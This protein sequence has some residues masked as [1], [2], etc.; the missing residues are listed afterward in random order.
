[1]AIVNQ[2]EKLV[3]CT[4]SLINEWAESKDAITNGPWLVYIGV[5]NICNIDCAVCARQ[6][7]MRFEKGLMSFDV[8]KKIV[9]QLPLSVRKV[10]LMKQGE[11]LLHPEF[12]RFVGYLRQVRPDIFISFHTNGIRA[13]KSRMRDILPLIDSLGISISAISR[14]TYRK[15]HGQDKFETVTANIADISQLLELID[16]DKRPHVF[17]DYVRQKANSSDGN[18]E[19][20][21]FFKENFNGLD[22]VDI[23]AVY[24]FQGEIDEGYT[25]VYERF[26]YSVFP[27]CVWPWSSITFC[28]DGKVSYCFVEPRENRFIGDITQESFQDI[29]NGE[30][31]VKFRQRM[32]NKEFKEL[33]DDGFYCNKCS[34]L[35]NMRS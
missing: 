4:T 21:N 33:A 25:D 14:E 24:N 35:W 2:T 11:P 29:W 19:V 6:R 26:D 17:I 1:M 3:K 22:S 16:P 13:V 31:F 32:A 30:Q 18:E 27:C 23:H 9:D 5:T 28:Y 10:Y 7:A 20:V 15:V 12:E 8:F 34:W